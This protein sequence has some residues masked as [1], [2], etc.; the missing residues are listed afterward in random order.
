METIK[1][2]A[3]C[4][5]LSTFAGGIVY[6]LAPSGATSKAVRTVVSVFIIS[7][8]ILPFASVKDINAFEYKEYEGSEYTDTDLSHKV[9]EQQRDAIEKQLTN[10]IVGIIGKYSAS[11]V[12]I[13]FDIDIDDDECININM[14]TVILS[15]E[16]SHL[17]FNI[18]DDIKDNLGLDADVYTEEQ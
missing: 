14:V 9:F 8:F 11:A 16:Y 5:T 17:I 3:L 10:Q 7:S 12:N 13:S 18:R 4:V 2:W 15:A 6:M 1:E